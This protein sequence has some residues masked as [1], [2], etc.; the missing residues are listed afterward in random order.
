M[1]ILGYYAKKKGTKNL[2]RFEWGK[3]NEFYIVL[4]KDEKE[5]HRFRKDPNDF[6][7]LEIGH[8]TADTTE[9]YD[10]VAEAREFLRKQGFLTQNLWSSPDVIGKAKEVGVEC[11][12]EQAIEI[13]DEIG[14]TID[15]SL[16][17]NWETI[18]QAIE[19]YFK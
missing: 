2:D 1:K 13:Y 9:T 16:G 14:R 8:T 11:T 10:K 5:I 18:E 15:C 19:N 12:E 7:I 17:V 3:D 6:E 4:Y